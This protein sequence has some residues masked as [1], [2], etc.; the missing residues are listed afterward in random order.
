MTEKPLTFSLLETAFLL[1][2]VSLLAAAGIYAWCVCEF[3][4]GPVLRA[5]YGVN[6]PV[7]NGWR[8]FP[9]LLLFSLAAGFACASLVSITLRRHGFMGT[10]HSENKI[11][12]EMGQ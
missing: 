4:I 8:V 9:L 6:D 7:I 1:V 5:G 2:C 3:T 11:F 10:A 12:P